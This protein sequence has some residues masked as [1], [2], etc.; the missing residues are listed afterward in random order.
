MKY[1]FSDNHILLLAA[2]IYLPLIFLGYGSDYDS[3]NVLWTGQYFAHNFDYVPSRVPGFFIYETLTFFFNSIGGSV[4]TNLSSMAM[5][6]LVLYVFMR[7]C[8]QYEIPHYRLLTLIMMV[9]PYFWV[10]ATCTMDYFF[11]IGFIYLGLLQV[12]RGKYFTAGVAFSFA[13]G[14]RLTVSL[15]AA[16]LLIWLFFSEKEK[17]G[18]IVQ[19]AVV[20]A[21]FGLMYYL[22]SADFAQWKPT[23]L[24][25]SVGGQE[26]WTLYLR[27]GRFGYK[28]IYFW[29][30][31]VFVLLAWGAIRLFG[32]GK[33]L[34][35]A[36]HGGLPIASIVVILVM[37]AFYLYI[38]T[39]P[40]YLLPTVGFWLILTAFAFEHKPNILYVMLGFVLLANF[41]NF[42]VAKPNVADKATGAEYG[43]WIEPGYLIAD[44]DARL[45]TIECGYQPC[46]WVSNPGNPAI[47]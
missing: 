34:I 25:A 11:A 15:I 38:P 45:E 29:S 35:N 22:P 26:Y 19:T 1:K 9:Q 21:F 32:K 12:M 27:L 6:I 16:V 4:L 36:K 5:A 41:V 18:Y 2:I 42:N 7:L 33:Q 37:E 8:K 24:S 3:Y 28:N 23:F 14:S 47:E 20:G 17:R 43:L 31:F 10:N 39:E 44:I 46:E 30:P 40:S 13:V